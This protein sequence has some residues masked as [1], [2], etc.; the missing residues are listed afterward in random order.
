MADFGS[1]LNSIG[2]SLT[3]ATSSESR[4]SGAG[5]RG[6]QDLTG[7]GYAQPKRIDPLALFGMQ[8]DRHSISNLLPFLMHGLNNNFLGQ[9][10]G[11]QQ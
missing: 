7:A 10:G 6:F 3:D 1:L 9:F 2:S 8:S 11:Q 4:L 5:M